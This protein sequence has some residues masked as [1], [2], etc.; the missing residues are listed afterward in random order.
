[1]TN[2]LSL[3]QWKFFQGDFII[4]DDERCYS[5][6]N[7][8]EVLLRDKVYIDGTFM[9]FRDREVSII[10]IPLTVIGMDLILRLPIGRTARHWLDCLEYNKVNTITSI[11]YSI[12]KFTWYMPKIN[13][14]LPG[15]FG[16]VKGN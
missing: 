5:I 13:G 12:R 9:D 16:K 2:R 3:C 14:Y 4:T 8:I 11:K 15:I 10:A 7:Y 1:M 6:G